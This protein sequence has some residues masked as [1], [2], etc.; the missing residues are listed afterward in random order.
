MLLPW[1]H[2][3]AVTSVLSPLLPLHVTRQGTGRWQCLA[4]STHWKSQAQPRSPVPAMLGWGGICVP[5]CPRCHPRA[6]ATTC[7][8]AHGSGRCLCRRLCHGRTNRVDPST[9]PRSALCTPVT[10]PHLSGLD[11]HAQCFIYLYFQNC[12][13]LRDALIT[14]GALWHHRSCTR[15]HPCQPSTP[16][17]PSPSPVWVLSMSPPHIAAAPPG[18]S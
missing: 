4:P 15:C 7:Q 1:H 10:T 6:T 2:A 3:A 8:A 12:Q 11:I 16:S 13:R 18:C 14:H 9:A 17:P 5:M